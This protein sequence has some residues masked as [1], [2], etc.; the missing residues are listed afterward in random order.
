MIGVYIYQL[1]Y[2]LMEIDVD[3]Q[4]RHGLEIPPPVSFQ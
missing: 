1:Q 4:Q 2:F 3:T